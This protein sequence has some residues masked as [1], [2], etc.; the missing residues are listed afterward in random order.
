[1]GHWL[2]RYPVAEDGHVDDLERAA[3]VHEMH[4][5]LPRDQAEATAHQKYKILSHEKGAAHHLNGMRMAKSRGSAADAE[6]HYA[7]YCSHMKVLGHNPNQAVPSSVMAHVMPE[8]LLKE[9]SPHSSD[10]L[11]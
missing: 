7:L 4:Y 1:M 5:G 8:P 9:Y 11:L 2:G 10:S 3:A 6:K